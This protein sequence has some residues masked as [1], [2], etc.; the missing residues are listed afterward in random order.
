[1]CKSEPGVSAGEIETHTAQ[2][3]YAGLQDHICRH[4]DLGNGHVLKFEVVL[5][6]CHDRLHRG[7]EGGFDGHGKKPV[8][9]K[10][11][12]GSIMFCRCSRIPLVPR[13]NEWVALTETH[14]RRW[15]RHAPESGP[16]RLKSADKE[17]TGE[18]GKSGR[19]GAR[20]V[21]PALIY[22]PRQG[23]A[24]SAEVCPPSLGSD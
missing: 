9:W 24:L 6:P 21:Q 23:P 19:K 11:D 16:R 22:A 12:A 14:G 3:G 18:V 4:L 17:S 20:V 2:A 10:F 8:K 15:Q 13:D 5:A 7:G 1:M